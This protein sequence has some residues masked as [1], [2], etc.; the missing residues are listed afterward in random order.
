[1]NGE[2]EINH[3]RD[4]QKIGVKKNYLKPAAR[5]NKK[6][7]QRII[8]ADMIIIGPGN[9]YCSIVPNLL[10]KGI[11]EAIN[12]SKAAVVYNCN[13]VNKLKHTEN[14]TLDDYTDS[15]NEYLGKKRIDYIT[16]NAKKPDSRLIKKYA[17]H[18][19]LLV[20]FK[21]SDRK[22]RNYRIIRAD[23]LSNKRPKYNRSDALAAQRSFIRHDGDKLARILMMIMELGDYQ[24]IIKKII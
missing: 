3:S 10:V 18:K 5:A 23:V 17:E 12:K 11:P 1:L 8:D 6:A 13:L 16:F 15:I 4:I 22:N 14:F 24:N 19:E 7:I 21:E 20:E 9:H 2:E